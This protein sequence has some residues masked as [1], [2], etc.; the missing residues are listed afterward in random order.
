MSGPAPAVGAPSGSRSRFPIVRP[1]GRPRF[2]PSDTRPVH[3]DQKLAKLGIRKFESKRLR[4]YT[5]IDPSIAEK[6]PPIVDQAYEAWE[7]YFGPLPPNR[8]G[9]EYQIT[10]YLMKDESLFERAKLVPKDLPKIEHG[11]H[12]GARFWMN[13]QKYDYYRRHLMLHEATH[14]FMTTLPEMRGPIW[15]FEGMAELF[16]THRIDASGRV[17]FRVMPHDKQRFAGWGRIS[18]VR[19]DVEQ[20]GPR[21][22]EEA[23]RPPANGQGEAVDYAWWW[24]LC[25]FLDSHPRYRDRFGQIGRHLGEE[26]FEVLFRRYF[27]DVLPDLW[28]EW[29]LFATGIEYGYDFQRAAIDFRSG[30]PLA[31]PQEVRQVRIAADRGWQSS[32]V[33]VREG[34]SYE[35]SASGRFVVA[36]EPKPWSSRTV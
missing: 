29:P 10:G 11:R 26:P 9:S 4:L 32:G 15:Y 35:I 14:C 28:T 24:A 21:S 12:R 3:D 20:H 34:Q 17:T 31:G 7:A 33:L 16:A 19:K 36:N 18:L 30:K 8:E 1:H 13:D 25:K 23:T 5:D 22:A 27:D 2:R 6:L